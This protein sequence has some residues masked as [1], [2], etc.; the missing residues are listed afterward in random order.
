MQK[1][2]SL[3]W[4]QV[5]NKTVYLYKDKYG[6]EFMAFTPFNFWNFRVRR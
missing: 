4:D 3:F 1:V 6:I 2:R 5:A